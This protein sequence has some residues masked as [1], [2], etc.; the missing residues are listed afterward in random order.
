MKTW[1]IIGLV[2]LAVISFIVYEQY[3]IPAGVVPMGDTS[4]TLAWV[5]LATA[6]VSLL[7]AIVGLL[8]KLLKK[9]A[10]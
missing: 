4:T 7:A 5:S 3:R 8:Q 9:G 6:I 2:V 1:I 10:E